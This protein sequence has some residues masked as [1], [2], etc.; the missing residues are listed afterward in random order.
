MEFPFLKETA[1]IFIMNFGRLLLL[2]SP[3]TLVLRKRF[4]SQ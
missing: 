2:K 3:F 1:Y 4:V